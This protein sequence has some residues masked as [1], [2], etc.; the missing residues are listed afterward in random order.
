[1]EALPV[2]EMQRLPQIPVSLVRAAATAASGTTA[3]CL[4]KADGGC[5]QAHMDNHRMM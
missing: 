1:M 5:Q 2:N 3:V 4:G